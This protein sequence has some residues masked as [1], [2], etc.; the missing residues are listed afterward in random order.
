MTEFDI[1]RKLYGRFLEIDSFARQH[2]YNGAPFILNDAE[3]KP[4]NVHVANEP[5]R[6][7]DDGR[8]FDLA[9]VTNEPV[10]SG[11][12]EDAQNTYTGV[13]YIDIYTPVDVGEK[14]SELKYRWISRLFSRGLYIDGGIDIE[15][16]YI[17]TRDNRNGTYRTQAAV[18]W[19]AEID[20]E[21]I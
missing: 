1:Q 4:A 20:K 11:L 9:L 10:P 6:E 8:W 16:C 13:L 19:F 17:S 12:Y 14:E 2:G 21:E 3:G 7:P 18:E 15:R 5:F